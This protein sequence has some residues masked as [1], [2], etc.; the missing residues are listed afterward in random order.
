MTANDCRG[1]MSIGGGEIEPLNSNTDQGTLSPTG[2]EHVT[3]DWIL[4]IQDLLCNA[5]LQRRT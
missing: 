4:T 5:G 3:T 1:N 2:L